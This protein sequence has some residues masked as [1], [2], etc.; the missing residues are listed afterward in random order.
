MEAQ[1]ANTNIS[2]VK[3]I[4]MVI[5]NSNYLNRLESNQ[6]SIF[7]QKFHYSVSKTL[8]HFEGQVI[9]HD[10]NSY[11]VAFTSATNAVLCALQI[12]QKFKYVTPK[13]DVG[14]RR[15]KIGLSAGFAI[16]EEA[17]QFDEAIT[18]AI[19]MCEIVKDTLVISP[20]VKGLYEKEN[21]NARIDTR[22]IRTLKKSEMVFLNRL[23]RASKR[24]W[25]EGN[26][27]LDHLR[28]ALGCSRSSFYRRVKKLTGKS[29]HYFVREF[30]LHRALNMLHK[31]RGNISKIAFETG[32]KNPSHFTRCF[33]E[34]FGILPSK[35]AQYYI[36]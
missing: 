18:E 22:H 16:Q 29:P 34:K 20:I 1:R 15:L 36:D 13:F 19:Q 24:I 17:G 26:L 10:N 5:E 11:L 28:S 25:S 35:Y 6:Y 30:R 2:E 21:R 3:R 14:N 8:R 33:S 9:N 27:N 23:M 4:F 31:R 32:F 7:T 12:E